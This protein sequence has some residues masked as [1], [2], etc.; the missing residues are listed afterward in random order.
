MAEF[1]GGLIVAIIVVFFCALVFF[2]IVMVGI[3]VAYIGV[4]V[5]TFLK[6]LLGNA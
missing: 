6:K 2:S 4:L 3:A 1:F 5:A